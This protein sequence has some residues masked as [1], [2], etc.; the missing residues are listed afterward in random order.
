MIEPRRDIC[1]NAQADA[2][3]TI[4][5]PIPTPAQRVSRISAETDVLAAEALRSGTDAAARRRGTCMRCKPTHPS[6]SAHEFRLLLNDLATYALRR[7]FLQLT[8]PKG[9]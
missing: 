7:M 4:R 8:P 3:V 9:R 1:I 2:S 5:P 6:P